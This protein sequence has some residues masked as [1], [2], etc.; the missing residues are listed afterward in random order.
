MQEIINIIVNHGVRITL[1]LIGAVILLFIMNIVSFAR[2]AYIKKQNRNLKQILTLS[3]G[4]SIE[5]S[6]LKTIEFTDRAKVELEGMEAKI[7]DVRNTLS[8]SVQN[9][10]FIRY[11][12]FGDVGSDLSFSVALLDEK[13]NGVVITNI[14]GRDDSNVYAKPVINGTSEYK[15]SVE[16]EHAIDRAANREETEAE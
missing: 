16:E 13:L 15:L 14:Y 2:I 4:E 12:A 10:G 11:N 1:G 3:D 7:E 6:L 9:I 5:T 8:K